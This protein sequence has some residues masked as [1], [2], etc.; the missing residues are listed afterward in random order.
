MFS[1]EQIEALVNEGKSLRQ[2]QKDLDCAYVTVQRYLK[3]Y[4]LKTKRTERSRL[5]KH[6]GAELTG[7]KQFFCNS[8]CKSNYY[9]KNKTNAS[10]LKNSKK[11]VEVGQAKRKELVLLSGGKCSI[12]GYDKNIAA[13]TFHHKDITTKKFGLSG[14]ILSNTPMEELKEEADKCILLCHNCHMEL[15]YPHLKNWK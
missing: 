12:C 8:R 6:C 1:K 4:G 2:M 11:Q 14:R 13:L 3:K 5:C 7:H 9:Y 10:V 15:H